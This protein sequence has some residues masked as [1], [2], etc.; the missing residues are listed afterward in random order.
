MHD[1]VLREHI[2]ESLEEL[3]TVSQRLAGRVVGLVGVMYLRGGEPPRNR[4][5]LARTPPSIAVEV[6]STT[7]RDHRRD[8]AEKVVDYAAFGIRWY[9]LVDPVSRTFEILE[10]GA[11]GRYVLALVATN[12]VVEEVPGCEGLR[13][14]LPELWAALD[15]PPVDE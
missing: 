2:V 9:W 7:P 14:N 10:L 1:L 5:A 11:D 12:E 4:D 15:S 6:I 13:L 3:E 8:R